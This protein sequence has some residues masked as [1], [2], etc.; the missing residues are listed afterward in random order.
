MKHPNSN[1]SNLRFR[2]TN[3]KNYSVKNCGQKDICVRKFY[4]PQ[5]QNNKGGE[6][7]NPQATPNGHNG[8]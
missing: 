1:L 6:K 4:R 7:T 2:C 5:A 8:I 3:F